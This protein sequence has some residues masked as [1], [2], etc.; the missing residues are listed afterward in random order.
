MVPT[1]DSGA[2]GSLGSLLQSWDLSQM[3]GPCFF[4]PLLLLSPLCPLVPWDLLNLRKPWKSVA[5]SGPQSDSGALLP[6]PPSPPRPHWPSG[7]SG[8]HGAFNSIGVSVRLRGLA[9]LTP[10]PPC[11]LGLPGSLRPLEPQEALEAF[12]SLGAS[13]RHRG[14]APLY[15]LTPRP[16]CV[17]L[18]LHGAY[19]ASEHLWQIWV[20]LLSLTPHV[21]WASLA[22]LQPQEALEAFGSLGASVRLRDLDPLVPSPSRPPWPALDLWSLRKPWE[23]LA[24]L[25]PQ[26]DSGALLETW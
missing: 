4:S 22:P 11:L 9:P 12:S 15:L 16:P 17:P 7:A 2:S 18:D 3:Q 1:W 13:V 14:L 5:V 19:G 25:G 23:P 21:P 20:P 24:V 10:S 6:F 8:S 26:S